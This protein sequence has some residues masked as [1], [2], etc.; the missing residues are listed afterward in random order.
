MRELRPVR[1]PLQL[2]QAIRSARLLRD[3]HAV[4]VRKRPDGIELPLATPAADEWD[5][6]I[7]L[8]LLEGSGG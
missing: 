3:G 4:A 2:K 7:R 6:V 1:L 5:R 8:D